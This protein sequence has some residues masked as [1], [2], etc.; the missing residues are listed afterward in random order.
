MEIAG[1]EGVSL[2]RIL[3]FNLGIEAICRTGI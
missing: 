1:S 3:C 2:C